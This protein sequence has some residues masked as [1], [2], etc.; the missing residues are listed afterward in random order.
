MLSSPYIETFDNSDN[1]LNE[2]RFFFSSNEM[3]IKD[4]KF[5]L[6]NE[7]FIKDLK[8]ND[9]NNFNNDIYINIFQTLPLP[10]P[11]SKTQEKSLDEKKGK[12]IK[13]QI[14]NEKK[15]K[16]IFKLN[17]SQRGPKK[18]KLTNKRKHSKYA[19]ENVNIKLKICVDNCIIYYI[20]EILKNLEIKIPKNYKSSKRL[21]FLKISHQERIKAI[22]KFVNSL[23]DKNLGD[24]IKGKV[25][26]KYG[27]KNKNNKDKVITKDDENDKSPNI[28]L[29]KEL[30]KNEDMKKIFSES[31]FHF[32]KNIFFKSERE[33]KVKINQSKNI[34]IKFPEKIKLF[35]DLL[36]TDDIKYQKIMRY[37]AYKYFMPGSIFMIN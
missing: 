35:N 34:L 1:S 4:K 13:F 24:I 20:N 17:I 27:K 11:F 18:K 31:Y 37:C 32:F 12:N 26:T 9:Q 15:I 8:E 22:N 14:K 7:R 5:D 23:N 10:H 36:K 6:T 21:E 29:F 16:N 2:N 3:E 28:I 19:K 25:S 30:E 33:I